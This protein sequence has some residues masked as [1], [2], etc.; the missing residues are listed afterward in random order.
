MGTSA[1]GMFPEGVQM[2]LKEAVTQGADNPQ[3][4]LVQMANKAAR[5]LILRQTLTSDTGE[6]GGGSKALG[7]VHSDVLDD[8]KLG[9]GNWTCEV[10]NQLI[11]YFCVLNFGNDDECPA[12]KV[13]VPDEDQSVKASETASNLSNGGIEPT[14][15]GLE[16]LSKKVGYGLRRKP[17]SSP[18][19][20]TARGSAGNPD[21][22]LSRTPRHSDSTI[23]KSVALAKAYRGVNAPI[24]EIVLQSATVDECEKNIGRFYTDWTPERARITAEE[25]FQL[26][27]MAI[28]D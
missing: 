18:G 12:A 5:N 19:I 26:C 17:P 3:L 4:L 7:E 15:D 21:K 27:Q 16:K 10:L 22:F 28:S 2:E 9:C 25:A 6:G 13:C 11:H 23:L 8:V 24:R 20:L 1:W 14:D